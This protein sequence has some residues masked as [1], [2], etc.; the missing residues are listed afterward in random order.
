[1]PYFVD[2][3][4]CLVNIIYI[5]VIVLDIMVHDKHYSLWDNCNAVKCFEGFHTR[6]YKHAPVNMMN[7]TFYGL[8][9]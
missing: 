7:V 9:G 8:S 4:L 1:M 5:P 3:T 6:A 2:I